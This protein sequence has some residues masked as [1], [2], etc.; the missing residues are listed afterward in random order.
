MVT[1]SATLKEDEMNSDYVGP[2]A[3][4]VAVLGV[5]GGLLVGMAISLHYAQ[6]CVA[7]L[8]DKPAAEIYTVCKSR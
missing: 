1:L 3:G 4:V 6:Q 2:I 5:F 8:K 7:A